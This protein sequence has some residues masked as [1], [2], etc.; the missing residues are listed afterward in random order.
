[1]LCSDSTILIAFDLNVGHP[2][3]TRK[4]QLLVFFNVLSFCFCFKIIINVNGSDFL[5]KK[6]LSYRISGLQNTNYLAGYRI[7][8][9]HYPAQP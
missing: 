5:N 6:A 8:K 2:V 7:A 1:M 4:L 9:N 3:L